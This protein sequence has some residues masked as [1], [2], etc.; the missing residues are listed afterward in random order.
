M[1]PGALQDTTEE[2]LAFEVPPTPVGTPGTAAG[3]T[4]LEAREGNPE[5]TPLAATTVKE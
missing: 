5:P 3:I 1:E 4:E 2:P